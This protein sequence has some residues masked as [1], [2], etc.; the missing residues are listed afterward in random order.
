M[1]R[2]RRYVKLV[3]DRKTAQLLL[4]VLV[5]IGAA[6]ILSSQQ[7][8][9]TA[10][11]PIPAGVYNQIVTT[12]NS[13]GAPADTTLNRNAG[14]A[15]LVPPTNAG[16]KVGIGTSSP[17]N[18]LDVVGTAAVT[19][20][21][22]KGVAEEGAAC[23][24]DGLVARTT[25]GLLLSCQSGV[26]AATFKV[27]GTDLNFSMNW[28][29]GGNTYDT[30]AQRRILGGRTDGSGGLYLTAFADSCCSYSSS[31]QQTYVCGRVALT[32]AK[33]CWFSAS[34]GG[35]Y[36]GYQAHG[37]ARL[38]GNTLTIWTCGLS[39]CGTSGVTATSANG[40]PVGSVVGVQ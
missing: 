20:I 37:R 7:L 12:G 3:V 31:S 16:G 23:T 24:P 40:T 35:W 4:A 28:Y 19:N 34:P 29:M 9:M 6:G 33:G 30:T 1:N 8:S 21:Q 32:S 27:P 39:A 38:V 25:T 13:G 5:M 11:Y 36:G 17:E 2:E 26:W 22:I 10:T 15:I 14:N 18:K